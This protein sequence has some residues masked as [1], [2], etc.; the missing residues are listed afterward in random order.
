MNNV[1]KVKVLNGGHAGLPLRPV[2]IPLGGELVDCGDGVR[3][4]FS[5]CTN[6]LL[7]DR[8]EGDNARVM[9]W[10][11]DVTASKE[12]Y[13]VLRA[14]GPASLPPTKLTLE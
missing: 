10:R 6:D 8:P 12:G 3:V 9:E 14:I 11:V 1:L 4:A 5:C 13:T 2:E 7:G